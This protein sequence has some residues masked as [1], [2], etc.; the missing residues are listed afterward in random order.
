MIHDGKPANIGVTVS[1]NRSFAVIQ[2]PPV[3]S[4]F[5][6]RRLVNIQGTILVD[7]INA[8]ATDTSIKSHRP[9]D[10]RFRVTNTASTTKELPSESMLTNRNTWIM[11][12]ALF[13]TSGC[14]A[15][16]V[17]I[18]FTIRHRLVWRPT[19][20]RGNGGTNL[21]VSP[22]CESWCSEDSNEY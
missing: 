12:S 11:I 10:F 16:I 5:E 20:Q 4:H 17:Y 9:M 2:F 3:L 15:V 18:Y 13:A 8:S 14:F 6:E 7:M 21:D 1:K 22:C 19:T